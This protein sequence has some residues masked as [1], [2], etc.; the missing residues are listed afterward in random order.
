MAKYLPEEVPAALRACELSIRLGS[1]RLEA[2]SMILTRLSD[3]RPIWASGLSLYKWWLSVRH[4]SS[5]LIACET[6][7]LPI[8]DPGTVLVELPRWR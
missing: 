8:V 1:F 6:D 2:V 7:E 4:L 3:R 5:A